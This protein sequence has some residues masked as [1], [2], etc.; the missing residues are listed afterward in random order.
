[1]RAINA[2]AAASSLTG[3]TFLSFWYAGPMSTRTAV[4]PVCQQ[5]LMLQTHP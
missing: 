2:A 4:F 1:M 5:R 3:G